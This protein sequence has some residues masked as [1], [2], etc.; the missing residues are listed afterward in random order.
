MG[1]ALGDSLPERKDRL[2][3]IQRLDLGL[4]VHA[5]HEGVLG[6]IE[7][8]ADDVPE[9]LLE[10]LVGTE[11]VVLQSVGLEPTGSPDL[12]DG[13]GADPE[14]G[15]HRPSRPVSGVG[16]LGVQRVMDDRPNGGVRDLRGAPG[17]RRISLE[18]MESKVVEPVA[19]KSARV[20]LYSEFHG[21][22]FVLSSIGGPQDD[23]S[24]EDEAMRSRVAPR[25]LLET[26]PFLR[27]ERQRSGHAHMRPKASPAITVAIQRTL[28]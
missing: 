28:H 20:G 23:P 21:D 15:G 1:L 25:P 13:V 8:E 16:R 27:G 4:F 10:V 11:F 5:E 26:L 17:P 7:V 19:P 24:A 6:W 22:L 9:L 14:L 18:T 2:G 12:M 3:S